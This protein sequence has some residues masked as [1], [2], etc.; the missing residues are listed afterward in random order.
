MSIKRLR[1]EIDINF[2]VIVVSE[3]EDSVVCSEFNIGHIIHPNVSTEK[4]NI[5]CSYL[6]QLGLDF[7]IVSGS[8]DLFSTQYLRNI[9][10]EMQNDVDVIGTKQLFVYDCDGKYRGTLKHITSKIIMGVGKTINKRVLDAV[11]WK[12]WQYPIARNWG[13]D[14]IL[15][16]TIAPYVKTTSIVEGI[17]VDCKSRESLNKF[18]MFETNR[19]GQNIDSSVFYNI[20]SKEERDILNNI[21]QVGIPINFPNLNKKGR[22]IA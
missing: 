5:G 18:S 9:M 21:H 3:K 8:D 6:Q 13:T 2:P 4:W 12:P 22:T 7:V 14:S 11:D 20:L 15:T 16:R 17:I 1:A 19:H 10:F